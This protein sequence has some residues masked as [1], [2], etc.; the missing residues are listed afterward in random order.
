M[1]SKRQ[2]PVSVRT[3][4][5][6]GRLT[7]KEAWAR[8]RERCR[9]RGIDPPTLTTLKWHL[10]VGTVIEAELVPNPFGTHPPQIYAVTTEA[11]D[12]FVEALVERGDELRVAPRRASPDAS[13]ADK[14]PTPEGKVAPS[15]VP[16]RGE[17]GELL[18]AK[19]ALDYLHSKATRGSRLNQQTFGLYLAYDLIPWR[20]EDRRRVVGKGDVDAFLELA[21][22]GV[23][24]DHLSYETEFLTER[25][26]MSMREAYVYYAGVDPDPL[27]MSSF[28]ALVAAGLVA[29]I[30]TADDPKAPILGFRKRDVDA[31][32]ALRQ[33]L[34]ERERRGEARRDS[35]CAS[36]RPPRRIRVPER[37]TAVDRI[38]QEELQK[39]LPKLEA[40]KHEAER[41]AL[42]A[43]EWLSVK[44]A[45]EYYRERAEE[46]RGLSWFR[47]KCSP[48]GPF[49]RKV[50]DEHGSTRAGQ[51]YLVRR[52]SIDRYVAPGS[53]AEP[54]REWPT[55]TAYYKF[56]DVIAPGV[57]LLRFTKLVH[58]GGI[59]S[60]MTDGGARVRREDVRAYFEAALE[61][62]DDSPPEEV[63]EKKKAKVTVSA[64]DYSPDELEGVLET[65]RGQGFEVEIRR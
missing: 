10:K 36:S 64:R 58:D 28:R 53:V 51:R 4:F 19:N 16:S 27:T 1:G 8:C 5:R 39:A 26:D 33:R 11:V 45:Y 13:T 60:T 62:E 49:E 61:L 22:T 48:E 31:F 65:L 42:T 40:A 38:M 2:A 7:T 30:R 46:P 34:V 17:P 35:A 9:E 43:A 50:D 57:S 32:L 21:P 54:E 47:A 18:D 24:A 20:W 23:Y 12:A 41:A 56:R 59:R 15:T 44:D 63:V 3:V 37:R 29:P 25:G 6:D 52:E 55:E 14:A